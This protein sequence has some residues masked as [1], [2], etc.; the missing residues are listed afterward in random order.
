[1]KW[2]WQ[3][4]ELREHWSLSAEELHLVAGRTDHGRMGFVVMLKFF[5]YQGRF[6]SAIEDLPIDVVLFLSQQIGAS[7][8]DLNGA[9]LSD[10][11]LTPAPV[12]HL[13]HLM[14]R[15]GH[16]LEILGSSFQASRFTSSRTLPDR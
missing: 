7:Q 5:Q 3:K 14:P 2:H 9:S 4:E 8:S 10:F 16:Q 1:V 12:R 13:L 15:R 11:S 6:P